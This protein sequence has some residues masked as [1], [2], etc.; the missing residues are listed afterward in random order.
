M[1]LYVG[2]L[3]R[4]RIRLLYGPVVKMVLFVVVLFRR[5]VRCIYGPVVK[6]VLFVHI[7]FRGRVRFKGQELKCSGVVFCE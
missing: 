7:L 4:G 1:V 3:C 5:C 6:M 2:V